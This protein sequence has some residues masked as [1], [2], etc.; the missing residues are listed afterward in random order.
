MKSE[1]NPNSLPFITASPRDDATLTPLWAESKADTP[2]DQQIQREGEKS[3]SA[4]QTLG[5]GPWN[6][7]VA[8]RDDW[9]QE[10]NKSPIER[11]DPHIYISFRFYRHQENRSVFYKIK[12]REVRFQFFYFGFSVK[13]CGGQISPRVL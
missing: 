4:R 7:D 2:E 8:T 13:T 10:D 11:M 3:L 1:G 12:N 6:S 9:E 5:R